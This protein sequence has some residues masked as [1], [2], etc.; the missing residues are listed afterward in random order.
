MVSKVAPNK[1]KPQGNSQLKNIMKIGSNE[2]ISE[3]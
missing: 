1:P 2:T 3:G